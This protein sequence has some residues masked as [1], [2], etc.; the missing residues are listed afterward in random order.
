MQLTTPPPPQLKNF[1]KS[2]TRMYASQDLDVIFYE[3]AAAPQRR[4]HAAIMAIPLPKDLGEV[5]PAYFKE[6]ILAADEEWT[7][8]KPILNTQRPE[9]GKAAFRRSLVKE[10]PYFHVW[11]TIDGGIGHVI[12]DETRWPRGDLFAR[13]LL[14]GMLDCEPGIAK[15]QGRWRPGKDPRVEEF[16]E[17]WKE[18]DWTTVLYG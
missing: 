11:F 6:A 4:K 9:L 13:E 2:L 8:H 5:A 3:N 16:K 17:G 14:A 18:W 12:E 7:Q 15:R 10:M 1:M